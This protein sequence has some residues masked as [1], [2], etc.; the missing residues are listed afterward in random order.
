MN[1]FVCVASVC[2]PRHPLPDQRVDDNVAAALSRDH[3][4]ACQSG[5][6]GLNGGR[7]PQALPCSDVSRQQLLSLLEN[8]GPQDG[9]LREGQT[10]PHDFEHRL[11][12]GEKA[13]EGSVKVVERGTAAAAGANLVPGLVG[14]P[15]Y[16]VR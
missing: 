2:P 3:V 12:F 5:E 1:K 13:M 4:V 8:D 9:S 10:F 7:A 6:R 11:L 15:L 16:V 14:E